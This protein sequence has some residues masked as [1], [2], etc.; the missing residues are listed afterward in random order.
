MISIENLV[1]KLHY[2]IHKFH[3]NQN[4]HL[5][6]RL[7]QNQYMLEYGNEYTPSYHLFD[8]VYNEADNNAEVRNNIYLPGGEDQVWID[9]FTGEQY[10]G[11][12][13]I[14]NF[15]APLWKLPL[16]VKNG[17]ILPKT[18]ENNSQLEVTGDEDRIFD[19]FGF[20]I[21]STDSKS[22]PGVA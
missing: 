4:Q 5:D 20:V 14:N 1:L 13:V 12:K 2:L 3:L 18:P 15:S 17:A 8:L 9:Y 16:F 22:D 19:T 6:F 21:I 11:G 10:T 7:N